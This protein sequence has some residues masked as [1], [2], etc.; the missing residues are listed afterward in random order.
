L[1]EYD[2]LLVQALQEFKDEKGDLRKPGD[3][4]IVKGPTQVISP[5]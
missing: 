1:N 5:G 3:K 2:A 4:W